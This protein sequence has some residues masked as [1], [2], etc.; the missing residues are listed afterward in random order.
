MK[1][2]ISKETYEERWVEYDGCE[3]LLKPYPVGLNDLKI[4]AD[5][6]MIITGDQR[7]KIFMDSVK[8]WR[9]LVDDN[10]DEIPYSKKIKELIFDHNLGGLAG[11]VY[12]FN[13]TFEASL[14]SEMTN[15]QPGQDGS[16]TKTTRPATTAEYK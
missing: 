14:R 4:S 2:N 15:L 7:K 16:L 11:F 1:I 6:S 5:Q 8:G 10:D 3:I 13:S 12:Q 9:G